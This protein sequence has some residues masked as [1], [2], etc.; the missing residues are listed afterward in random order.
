MELSLCTKDSFEEVLRAYSDMVYRLAFSR[1]KNSFDAN[2]VTQEVFL[3]YIRAEK[4]YNDEEHRKAWLIK[5]TV[6]TSKTLVLSSWNRRRSSVEFTDEALSG[7][8]MLAVDDKNLKNIETKSVVLSAVMDLPKKYR[9]VIHLFY[10]ED[11]SLTDIS[12]TTGQTLNTIK[13][14]LHRARN[15][16]KEKLGEFGDMGVDLK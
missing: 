1:V 13:S 9:T 6:N 4:N 12:E 16:L 7:N 15:L 2:D 11:M 3:K 14:Q 8:A 10:Y 5:T